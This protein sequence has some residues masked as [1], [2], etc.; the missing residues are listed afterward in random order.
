MHGAC[1][2]RRVLC[3]AGAWNTQLLCGEDH[4]LI[5]RIKATAGRGYYLNEAQGVYRLHS[6]DQLHHQ[7]DHTQFYVHK[8]TAMSIYRVWLDERGLLDRA[9]CLGMA[10]E[11]RFFAVRL[12]LQGRMREKNQA[13]K[14]VQELGLRARSPLCLLGFLRLV[15]VKWFYSMASKIRYYRH[16]RAKGDLAQKAIATPTLL[17]VSPLFPDAEG[18]GPARRAE[19]T[20]R[21]LSKTYQVTLLVVSNGVHLSNKS[22]NYDYLGGR[23][24][25]V[26]FRNGMRLRVYRK[27]ERRFPRLYALLGH[28]PTDLL[29][30]EGN[31]VGGRAAFGAQIFE[32]VHVFRLAMAPCVLHIRK[33]QPTRTQFHLDVDDIES[34]ACESLARLMRSNGEAEKALEHECKSNAY[35]Q[36]ERKLFTC[37]DRLYV[38]SVN[39][40][41]RLSGKHSD[42]R[43]LPNVVNSAPINVSGE[44]PQGDADGVYRLLFVGALNYYPNG[45]AVRWFCHEVIPGLRGVMGWKFVVGGYAMPEPLKALL[46]SIS[47]AKQIGSFKTALE[48][49][50]QGDALVVPLRAGAGTRI[51]IL[52]AFSFGKPVIST[53]VG[54]G[55]IEAIPERDFLLA[56]TPEDFVRQISRLINDPELGASLVRHAGDFVRRHYSQKVAEEAVKYERT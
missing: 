38:S 28:F 29:P 16:I 33:T 51:K 56:D 13:F 18:I 50:S 4:E 55:G 8:I 41:N 37:F 35:S 45:D 9:L 21:A 11:Y 34:I 31:R 44:R 15:N 49:F 53:A 10:K 27:L 46:S 32:L 43:L 17:F 54:I 48:G 30:Y 3:A 22:V 47:E 2:R 1:Y 52:E 39:D 7:S 19:M 6:R 42:V 25:H 12:A 26:P 5:W 14:A 36:A 20:I 23:W 24:T 40:L